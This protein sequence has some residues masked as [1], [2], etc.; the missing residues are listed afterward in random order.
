MK[1]CGHVASVDFVEN[2]NQVS[3]KIHSCLDNFLKQ[4]QKVAH[5][6][7]RPATIFR[8]RQNLS[9]QNREAPATPRM[10]PRKRL[11]EVNLL[12]PGGVGPH[13]WDY[14]GSG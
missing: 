6:P 4:R 13:R 12:K 3:H 10:L 2:Q 1:P 11:N 7:T 5:M 9:N 8:S 14:T